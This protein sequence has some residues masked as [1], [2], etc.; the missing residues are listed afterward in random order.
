LRLAAERRLRTH[1]LRQAQALFA[2]H[3]QA[4]RELGADPADPRWGH[5][6][7]G[8]ARAF[9]ADGKVELARGILDRAEAAAVSH[10]WTPVLAAVLTARARLDFDVGDA[11]AS[12][13]DGHRA[14]A[15]FARLDDPRGLADCLIGL[16]QIEMWRWHLGDAMRHYRDAHQLA[17]RTGDRFQ[18]GATLRGMGNIRACE[19]DLAG[20]EELLVRALA[21]FQEGG[22]RGQYATCLNDLGEVARLRSDLARAEALYRQALTLMEALAAPEA[23]TPRFNLGLVLL[24]KG[25][26]AE[27]RR[28][29]TALESSLEGG[30][31]SIDL[32]WTHVALA[33]CAAAEADWLAW[34]RYVAAVELRLAGGLVDEDLATLATR[35]A[36]LTRDAADAGRARRLYLTA[37]GLW[38]RLAQTERRDACLRAAAE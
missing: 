25:R 1:D 32:L 23:S 5:G 16:G 12:H 37:A 18:L 35:A 33:A 26:F 15:V 31:R 4:L 9:L 17:L 19:D 6:W 34:D 2:A 8:R 36:D 7:V 13:R 10:G 3:E 20:G 24:E 28:H 30:E 21:L 14:L 38:E 27:A 29:F 22:N 11:D